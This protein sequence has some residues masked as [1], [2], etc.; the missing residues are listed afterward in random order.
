[1]TDKREEAIYTRAFLSNKHP[2]RNLRGDAEE[3]A[4]SD[5]SFVYIDIFNLCDATLKRAL[6]K[7]TRDT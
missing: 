5:D 2:Y 3:K 7:D 4:V 1:M 6:L